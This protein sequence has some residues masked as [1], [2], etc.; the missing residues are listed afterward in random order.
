MRE[1]IASQSP[2][3]HLRKKWQK[4]GRFIVLVFLSENIRF[5]Q[6]LRHFRHKKI[7]YR[8]N[9]PIVIILINIFRTKQNWQNNITLL[10]NSIS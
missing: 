3:L 2:F 7:E 9:F 10:L 8:L 1:E 6:F 5:F 4:I